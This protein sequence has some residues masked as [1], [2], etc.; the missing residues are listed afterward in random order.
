MA[1]TQAARNRGGDFG[2]HGHMR[3]FHGG[4]QYAAHGVDQS[5]RAALREREAQRQGD[6]GIDGESGIHAL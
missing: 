3:I 6:Y 4:M 5:E 1:Q 2:V